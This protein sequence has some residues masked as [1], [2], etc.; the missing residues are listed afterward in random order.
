MPLKT[1]RGP[2][3][4]PLMAQAQAE[5]GPEAVVLRTEQVNGV[6]ELLAA[7]PETADAVAKLMVR[8]APAAA[9]GSASSVASASAP[10]VTLSAAKGPASK[11]PAIAP[12]RDILAVAVRASS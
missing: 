11:A 8:S 2:T 4:G 10:G 9:Q 12:R 1:Y 5:L 6:I 3:A 7:D